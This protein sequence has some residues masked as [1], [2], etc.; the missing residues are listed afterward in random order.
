MATAQADDARPKGKRKKKFIKHG[1][2]HETERDGDSRRK[3]A[4]RF[5]TQIT[6]DGE[7]APQP[8]M[9]SPHMQSDQSEVSAVNTSHGHV[10]TPSNGKVLPFVFSAS[11]VEATSASGEV[12]QPFEAG[13]EQGAH[14]VLP[15]TSSFPE[16]VVSRLSS[17]ESPVTWGR[18]VRNDA[19]QRSATHTELR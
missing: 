9:A 15:V 6:L 19:F 16:P 14:E 13:P 1:Y 11:E 7:T 3:A 17:I 4:K 5:L 12:A 8:P 18:S 2:H 10:R